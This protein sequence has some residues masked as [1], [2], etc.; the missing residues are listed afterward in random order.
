MGGYGPF[1]VVG[2]CGSSR[3]ICCVFGRSTPSSCARRPLV[4]C[5]KAF[6]GGWNRGASQLPNGW[7]RRSILHRAHDLG[8]GSTIRDCSTIVCSHAEVAN[9]EYGRIAHWSG[10]T[11][12]KMVLLRAISHDTSDLEVRG[13]P[14][15]SILP[16]QL[17]SGSHSFIF[18]VRRKRTCVF[19]HPPWVTP[20]PSPLLPMMSI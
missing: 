12:Y 7:Y 17:N 8:S 19:V 15:D 10:H 1:L 2:I 11:N 3:N 6:V 16:D 13:Q 20:L 18:C 4:G 5:R 14:G 9:G